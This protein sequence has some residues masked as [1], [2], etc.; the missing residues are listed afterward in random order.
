MGVANHKG[1][2]RTS[3]SD[4]RL[5]CYSTIGKS[6]HRFSERIMLKQKAADKSDSLKSDRICRGYAENPEGKMP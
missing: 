5:K 2:R 6:G 1:P 3:L 4:G